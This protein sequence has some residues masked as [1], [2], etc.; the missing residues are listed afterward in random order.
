VGRVIADRIAS[1]GSFEGVEGH[2]DLLAACKRRLREALVSGY[3]GLSSM[4]REWLDLHG[5][6]VLENWSDAVGGVEVVG[7]LDGIVGAYRG[8]EDV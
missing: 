3:G 7:V 2:N 8:E 1:G 5:V 6:P 4:P